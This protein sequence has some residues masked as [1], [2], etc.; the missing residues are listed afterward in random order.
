M[1]ADAISIAFQHSQLSGTAGCQRA[2]IPV[3]P[4]VSHD[5]MHRDT[6][7]QPTLNS[8]GAVRDQLQRLQ[9]RG[10]PHESSRRRSVMTPHPG[11]RSSRATRGSLT[12]FQ[13]ARS[14]LEK[15]LHPYL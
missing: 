8:L 3:P 9:D 2:H 1:F 13:I 10:P 11:R 5:R 14:S 7:M 12:A 15:L 6:F 4:C